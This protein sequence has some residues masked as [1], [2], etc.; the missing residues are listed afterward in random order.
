[1]DQNEIDELKSEN[2]KLLNEISKVKKVSDTI[3]FPNAVL[4]GSYDG[5]NYVNIES[6]QAKYIR[7]KC[8]AVGS[9]EDSIIVHR[10]YMIDSCGVKVQRIHETKIKR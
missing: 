2:N 3:E 8:I 5:I 1:M 7:I 9:G 4:M 6:A 10:P